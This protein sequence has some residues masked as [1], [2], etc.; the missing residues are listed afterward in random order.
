MVNVLVVLLA[1]RSKHQRARGGRVSS[2]AT[3]DS[4]PTTSGG[5]NKCP[6][7]LKLSHQTSSTDSQEDHS[8]QGPDPQPSLVSVVGNHIIVSART[9]YTFIDDLTIVKQSHYRP[10]EAL[11]VPGG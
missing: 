9:V 10:G 6:S 5:M 3:D 7:L 2:S 8:S 1:E 4:K 11:R